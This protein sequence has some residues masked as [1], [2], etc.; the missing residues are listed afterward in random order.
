MNELKRA[1][2]DLTNARAHLADATSFA[3]KAAV[4]AHAD[5]AT[6]VD[7]AH[8][9]WGGGQNFVRSRESRGNPND[10]RTPRR[11]NALAGCCY[12]LLQFWKVPYGLTHGPPSPFE[13]PRAI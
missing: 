2:R 7:L 8:P 6:E 1:A 13:R 10:Q 3:A 9:D 5:G 11:H 4:A 12:L